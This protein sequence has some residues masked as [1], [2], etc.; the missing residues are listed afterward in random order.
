MMKGRHRPSDPRDDG[1]EQQTRRLRVPWVTGNRPGRVA[2]VVS[3]V[4]LCLIAAGAALA[5]ISSPGGQAGPIAGAGNSTAAAGQAA[6]PTAPAASSG[7]V[8][9]PG[10]AS[11]GI[12][13]TALRWPPGL[14]H[15][16]LRWR[17]GPGGAAWSQVSV[18]L[19]NAMQA[20]GVRL[21]AQMRLACVSLGSSVQ[22][23]QGAPPIPDAAMQ[24]LYVKVLAGLSGAAADCRSA[25]SAHSQGGD[26]QTIDLNKALLNH[27]LAEFAAG[28]KKLYTATAEIRTLHV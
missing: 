1:D 2:L 15:Q 19:G 8:T 16:M 3:A 17:A 24:R 4:C 26:T 22:A 23:A 11:D 5:A 13:K 9:V 25:I 12:A 18:R 10:V 28:S 6:Q 27:A 14:K 21:Y 20:A 7:A